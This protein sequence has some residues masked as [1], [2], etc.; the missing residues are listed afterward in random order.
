MRNRVRD[1]RENESFLTLFRM[2]WGF[3]V[4]DEKDKKSR[5]FQIHVQKR[6]ENQRISRNLSFRNSISCNFKITN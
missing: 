1:G 2:A 6:H 4:A 3:Q 5:I